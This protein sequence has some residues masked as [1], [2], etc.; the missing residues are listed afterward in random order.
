VRRLSL[1]ILGFAVAAAILVSVAGGANGDPPT[2]AFYKQVQASYKSV[3]AVLVQRRG[4]LWYTDSVK[5]SLVRWVNGKKPPVGAGYRP[6]SESIVVLLKN[7]V[8]TKYV[9]TAK[10][11]GL[12]PLTLLED[13]TGFWVALNT[14]TGGCYHASTRAADVGGWH[15]PFVGIYGTFAPMT[16]QGS[17][18]V[19]T[20]SYPWLSGELATE[21]DHI[22]ATTKHLDSYSVKITGASPITFTATNTDIP[23]PSFVPVAKPRCTT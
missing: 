3:P 13:S 12:P 8:V 2:I 7:G 10:A 21:T 6:A 19:V 16:T 17:T 18:V 20:S 4:F 11:P 23:V 14:K 5:G 1:T 22:S 9:D 15:N